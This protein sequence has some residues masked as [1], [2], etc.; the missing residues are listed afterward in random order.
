M[1]GLGLLVL[2]ES[3]RASVPAK[4]VDLWSGKPPGEM[5]NLGPEHDTTKADGRAVAGKRVTRLTN[6]TKPSISIY[7]APK[8]KNTGA[9]VIV[10]PGG[11]Y[12][13]LASDLEGSEVCEWLNSLGITG[14]LLKYRVPKNTNDNAHIGPLMDAQRALG[15]VRHHAEDWKIDP[16]RIGIMGFSAGGHL[17]ANLSNNYE[18]RSYAPV[19][20]ADQESCRPDFALL[21]YPGAML[22]SKESEKL[23]PE[24]KVSNQTPQTFIVMAADDPVRPENALA[25]T[26]ALKKAK[27]PVELH[28]YPKGGH[29][30]G[31]RRQ[32]DLAVTTWPDRAADWLRFQGIIKP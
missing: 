23:I 13:I 14:V 19:D 24:L 25:Y 29:G 12:S 8:R 17:S 28:I 1:L 18:K 9:A 22:E 4:V 10:C 27:V 7:P 16:K 3:S 26:L 15:W 21:I 11:G 2:P 20:E 30:Y 5:D 32:K 6:V 31:P